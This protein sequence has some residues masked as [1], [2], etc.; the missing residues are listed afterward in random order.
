MESIENKIIL[1]KSKLKL[2]SDEIQIKKQELEQIERELFELEWVKFTW[3]E[4][5]DWLKKNRPNEKYGNCP[6]VCNRFGSKDYCQ[7]NKDGVLQIGAYYHNDRFPRG[8]DAFVAFDFRS[9][10]Q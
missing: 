2:K 5:E 10:H 9:W 1:I 8:N 7:I 3:Q 6:V 4:L